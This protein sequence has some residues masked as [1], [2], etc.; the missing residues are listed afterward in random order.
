MHALPHTHACAHTHT[1]T[2]ARWRTHTPA[3]S[4]TQYFNLIISEHPQSKNFSVKE[5]F[6]LKK[7]RAEN[8][9]GTANFTKHSRCRVRQGAQLCQQREQVHVKK[10]KRRKLRSVWVMPPAPASARFRQ[11]LHTSL[12]ECLWFFWHRVLCRDYHRSCLN[13]PVS[14]KRIQIL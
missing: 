12:L 5:L 9:N 10:K 1:Q 11:R 3:H 2:L 8:R 13:G 4:F 14:L 7:R 6:S